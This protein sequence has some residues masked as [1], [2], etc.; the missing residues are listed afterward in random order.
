MSEFE[1]SQGICRLAKEIVA[2][3]ISNLNRY[4]EESGPAGMPYLNQKCVAQFS[5]VAHQPSLASLDLRLRSAM[6]RDIPTP[7]YCLHESSVLLV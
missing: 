2:P 7:A 1:I 4:R 6:A 5:G 3:N